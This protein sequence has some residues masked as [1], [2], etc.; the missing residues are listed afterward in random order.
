[1]LV[2]G[3]AC[4]PSARAVRQKAG[5]GWSGAAR[6][7]FDR[8]LRAKYLRPEVL[9]AIGSVWGGLDDVAIEITPDE[10]AIMVRLAVPRRRTRLSTC[11]MK[12]PGYRTTEG[13][14]IEPLQGRAVGS[15]RTGSQH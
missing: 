4:G 7:E 6:P 14:A 15:P 10:V 3:R 2:Q 11:P 13:P 9:G 8:R 5:Q 12:P 1:M